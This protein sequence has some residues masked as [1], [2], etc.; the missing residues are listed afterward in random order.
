MQHYSSQTDIPDD[1]MR[2]SVV[3][4]FTTDLKHAVRRLFAQPVFGLTLLVTLA[5]SIGVNIAVFSL[6]DVLF[7]HGIPY[8]NAARLAI[9]QRAPIFEFMQSQ[10]A[11][12]SWKSDCDLL[13]D[14]AMWGVGS[15]AFTGHGAPEQLHSADVTGNLFDV[16]GVRAKLG[17]TFSSDDQFD[18]Q[19]HVAVISDRLWRRRFGGDR[20]IPG[21]SVLLNG[22]TFTII[23][24]APA[25]CDFPA[26]TDVWTP[27][28][29]DIFAV[30]RSN[31]V[32]SS[33]LGVIKPGVSLAQVTAQQDAWMNGHKTDKSDLLGD[34]PQGPSVRPLRAV[35][36]NSAE[37]PVLLLF[38][39]VLLVLLIGCANVVNLILVD[40]ASREREFA[41]KRAVGMSRARMVRQMLT[42]NVLI[43]TLGGATGLGMAWI[44]F[45]LLK[46]YIPKDWPR[47]T[48]LRLDT[49]LLLFALGVSL[50]CGVIAGLVPCVR[51][52]SSLDLKLGARATEGG[53]K[54]FVRE[55]IVGG[56]TALATVLLIASVLFVRTLRNVVNSDCGFNPDHVIALSVSRDIATEDALKSTRE[57]YK[58]ALSRLHD[59]P[60][61][62]ITGGIDLLPARQDFESILP[63]TALPA[64]Q[65][66][67]PINA[68][69]QVVAPGYFEAMTIPLLAG[70]DFSEMDDNGQQP[71]AVIDETLAAKL[72]PAGNCI[73]KQLS[74]GTPKPLTVIGLVGTV[75]LIG[76]Y[77][78]P[79][80]TLYQPLGQ[81]APPQFSFVIKCDLPV[82]SVEPTLGAAIRQIDQ[83]QPV[84]IATLRSY[85][86]RWSQTTRS[87]TGLL[88]IMSGLG[89]LLAIVGVWGLV[90]Y[91]AAS[92]TREFAVRLALGESPKRVLSRSVSGGARAVVAGV[93]LGS[94]LS[95]ADASLIQSQ[96]FG[97]KAADPY[98]MILAGAVLVFAA[99]VACLFA[100]RRAIL[101]DPITVLREE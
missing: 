74:I 101:I 55:I 92:R 66:A 29:Y 13:A 54:R 71:I 49:T 40:F 77:N 87:I 11:F 3:R 100:A 95:L 68:A 86:D 20:S 48:D 17:R 22:Q 32:F 85:V 60:G 26:G 84:E 73:G 1:D 36:L 15:V 91:S 44:S 38:G 56:E 8:G 62:K 35:L 57:F 79:P 65:D 42:E 6:V 39:S 7:V 59:L 78:D 51:A 82:R 64:A 37:Q 5:L 61:V 31:A 10:A 16:L 24:V 93:I 75:R 25:D 45:P 58:D 2:P 43:S 89:L 14:A 70:R 53:H 98:T 80:P 23:G 34:Y 81:S 63:A 19:S 76:P 99:V 18:G 94:G 30:A 28:A 97:V 41:V 47:F 83:N 27:T 9:L 4:D 90:S 50:C 69:A 21:T 12:Q 33:V 46:T 88:E 52:W 72:W 67:Q 96:M